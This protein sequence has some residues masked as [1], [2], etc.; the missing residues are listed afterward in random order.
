[1]NYNTFHVASVSLAQRQF[2]QTPQSSSWTNSAF[3][4]FSPFLYSREQSRKMIR[5]L[6]TLI[7]EKFSDMEHLTSEDSDRCLSNLLKSFFTSKKEKRM[8]PEKS[9]RPWVLSLAWELSLSLSEYLPPKCLS[10][11]FLSSVFLSQSFLPKKSPT[12]TSLLSLSL[13]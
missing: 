13:L 10:Q 9:L 2:R 8:T 11:A 12:P 5:G 3:V 4:W 1:M 6:T 7:N